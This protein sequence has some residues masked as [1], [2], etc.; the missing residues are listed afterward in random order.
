MLPVKSN[1]SENESTKLRDDE[2]IPQMRYVTSTLRLDLM[3][4]LHS[5]VIHVRWSRI[6]VEYHQ[7]GDL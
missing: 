5:Q 2:I 1:A 7:L 3:S 6:N 4:M